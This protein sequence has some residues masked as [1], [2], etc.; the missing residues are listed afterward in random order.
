MNTHPPPVEARTIILE[1]LDTRKILQKSLARGT[2]IPPATVSMVLSGQRKPSTTFLEKCSD[3]LSLDLEA[4][5][6]SQRDFD[7]W[8]RT[9]EGKR[10]LARESRFDSAHRRTLGTLVNWQIKLHIELGDLEITPPDDVVFQVASVDFTR[11]KYKRVKELRADPATE[12]VRLTIGPSESAVIYSKETIKLPSFIVGRVGGIS[13]HI[14]S[15]VSVSFGLQLDPL[16][17]GLPFA[18]FTNHGCEN[19]DLDPGEPCFSVEFAYLSAEAEP[20]QQHD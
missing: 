11:G 18:L 17:K 6:K 4:L 5:V 12:G 10:I 16:W 14:A 13:Y 9:E 19:F 15:G 2:K 7:V 8:A 1:A 3:Y 20:E